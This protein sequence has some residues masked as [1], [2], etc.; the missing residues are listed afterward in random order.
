[1]TQSR[2]DAKKPEWGVCIEMPYNR[3]DES[4]AGFSGGESTDR[5]SLLL[6]FSPVFLCVFAP[7]RRMC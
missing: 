3:A 1:L 6:L 4:L 2:K 7:L 5:L